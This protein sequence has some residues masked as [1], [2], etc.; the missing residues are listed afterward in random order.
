MYISMVILCPFSLQRRG[1]WKERG[2][3]SWFVYMDL[4]IL[5]FDG[6]IEKHNAKKNFTKSDMALLKG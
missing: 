4:Q 3:H 2:V 5:H 6:Q 1:G